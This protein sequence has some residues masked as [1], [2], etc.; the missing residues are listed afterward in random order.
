MVRIKP[1][2]RQRCSEGSNKTFF[3]F[4]ET[5]PDLPLSVWLSPVEVWV[6]VACYRDRGSG[7]RRPG[8]GISPLGGVCN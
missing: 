7:C 5:E 3:D 2:T 6:A 8:Y 4:T 1:H